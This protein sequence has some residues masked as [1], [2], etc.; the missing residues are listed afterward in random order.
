MTNFTRKHFQ[1]ERWAHGPEGPMKP[2]DAEDE[3]MHGDDD[4]DVDEDDEEDD[5]GNDARA[6]SLTDVGVTLTFSA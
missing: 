3:E 5:D 6:Y 4:D 2:D 1:R